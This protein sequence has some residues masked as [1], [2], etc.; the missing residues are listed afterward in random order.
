MKKKF[1]REELRTISLIKAKPWDA[2]FHKTLD[3]STVPGGKVDMY[4]IA[5]DET[6]EGLVS[7]AVPHGEGFLAH[8]IAA[9]CADP[10]FIKQPEFAAM[11]EMSVAMNRG[12]ASFVEN[13]EI[14]GYSVAVAALTIFEAYM[15]DLPKQTRNELANRLLAQVNRLRAE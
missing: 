3:N 2:H 5:D 4:L 9:C 14:D 12:L 10:W 8:W 7:V 11:T 1:T 15:T 13:G 6:G